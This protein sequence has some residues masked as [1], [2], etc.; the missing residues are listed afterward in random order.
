MT[1][2]GELINKCNSFLCMYESG[3][4]VLYPSH[5]ITMYVQ[6]YSECTSKKATKWSHCHMFRNRICKRSDCLIDKINSLP[7]LKINVYVDVK[8]PYISFFCNLEPQLIQKISK[9]YFYIDT[10]CRFSI[11]LTKIMS[12]YLELLMILSKILHHLGVIKEMFFVINFKK[13][14]FNW[15]SFLRRISRIKKN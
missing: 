8:N 14:H 3:S 1:H 12:R 7:L 15:Q 5:W 2:R 13:W 11:N 10:C 4:D 9:S 6:I